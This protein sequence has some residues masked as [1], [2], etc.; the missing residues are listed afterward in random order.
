MDNKLKINGHLFELFI[1]HQQIKRRIK[2]MAWG[3]NKDLLPGRA[4]VPVMAGAFYFAGGF[5]SFI[6]K[7]Y[8]LFSVQASSYHGVNRS[9]ELLISFLKNER[10]IEGAHLVILEDV[11]D[12]GR[13][14]FELEKYF[15]SKGAAHV[16]VV[17][18][19]YKPGQQKYECNLTHYGFEV[20]AEF[21]IGYGM[22][23]DEEGRD[24]KDVYR[25]IE[26]EE[27]F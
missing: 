23:F 13:T 6:D 19:F 18:L 26:N 9:E 15:Y 10:L 7:P 20:G 16:E 12:S 14:A 17:A 24:L 25:W 11:V 3:F 22:D 1:S 8:R 4:M 2:E 5:L 27:N 21:L